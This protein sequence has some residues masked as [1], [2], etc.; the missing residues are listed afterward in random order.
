MAQFFPGVLDTVGQLG[1]LGHGHGHGHGHSHGAA[2]LGPSVH[3]AWLAGGSIVV[4]EWLYRASTSLLFIYL[5]QCKMQD[6]MLTNVAMKVAKDNQ[7]MALQVVAI[8]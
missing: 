2:M 1:M 8:S 3:A 6:R 5:V 4:K 7:A